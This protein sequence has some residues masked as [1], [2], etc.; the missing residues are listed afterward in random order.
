MRNV[1]QGGENEALRVED[2][3]VSYDL[4]GGSAAV[5]GVSFSIA[6]GETL[7]L[8]GESG[9]GKTT[10]A[11]AILDLVPYPGRIVSGAVIFEGRDLRDLAPRAMRRVR[12]RGIAMVHQEPAA[13]MDPLLRVSSQMVEA[14]RAHERATRREAL[15]KCRRLLEEV[16]IREP[17]RCLESFPHQLSGGILQ[18]V[19]I[20]TAL[21]CRPRL[22]I[23]DEPTSSL[24]VTVQAQI[25][26][27]LRQLRRNR[28]VS[29]LLISHDLGVVAQLAD[30]VAVMY[31]G[32][33][34]ELAQV[35]DLFA[36]P[37]HPYTRRL[38]AMAP[39]SERSLQWSD[40]AAPVEP[41]PGQ[42]IPRHGCRYRFACPEAVAVCGLTDPTLL[43]LGDGRSVRC[44]LREDWTAGP[45]PRRVDE[46]T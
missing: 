1:S 17:D 30:R 43:R 16:G 8:V 3:R 27:L 7:G 13:A 22:I 34:V 40:Y 10:L 45:P 2:L 38:M 36:R 28:G 5:D 37:C 32:Q 21:S 20:A 26:E 42:D 6:N 35:R 11:L 15:S 44:H 31:A 19:L 33:I 12:G 24:D 46:A 25:L 29:M 23:G 39:G 18:R 14:V 4:G 41:R 9:S